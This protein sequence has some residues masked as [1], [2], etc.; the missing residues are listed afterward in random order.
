MR[1]NDRIRKSDRSYLLADL[2]V[3][4]AIG[5]GSLAL[6]HRKSFREFGLLLVIGCRAAFL[7][8]ITAFRSRCASTAQVARSFRIRFET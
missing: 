8:F 3:T 7:R 6:A 1:R 2:A 5:F 4:T